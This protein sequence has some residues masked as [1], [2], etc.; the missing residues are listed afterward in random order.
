MGKRKFF[1]NFQF[2]ILGKKTFILIVSIQYY[3]AKL[4]K[5]NGFWIPLF[6]QSENILEPNIEYIGGAID[7]WLLNRVSNPCVFTI[8]L[9]CKKNKDKFTLNEM[10]LS[11]L[12]SINHG[13]QQ[14]FLGRH[15]SNMLSLIMSTKVGLI[16]LYK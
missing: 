15:L 2:Y 3:G 8:L 10:H 14:A 1:E 7:P 11:H 16:F 13:I 5:R 9:W 6:Y 12:A 4:T